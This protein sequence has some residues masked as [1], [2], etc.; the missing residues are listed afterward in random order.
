MAQKYMWASRRAK[1]WREYQTTVVVEMGGVDADDDD[2]VNDDDS[3]SDDSKFNEWGVKR[4]KIEQLG[5]KKLMR[6][7]KARLSGEINVFFV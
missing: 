5:E 7:I 2:S 4:Q 3:G 6:L 1:K